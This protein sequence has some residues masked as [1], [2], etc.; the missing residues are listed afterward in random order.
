MQC[1]VDHTETTLRRNIVLL[2]LFKY[3]WDNIAQENYF[4]N[5]GLER[6]DMFSFQIFLV[7][8]FLTRCNIAEQSRHSSYTAGG[9]TLNR[10]QH[11]IE[12]EDHPVVIISSLALVLWNV[13]RKI[14]LSQAFQN[15]L[16]FFR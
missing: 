5:V 14:W 15:D 16:T 4:C 8:C 7:D 9:T 6:S 13:T 11:W 2:M 3:V 10:G 1:Y 12:Q